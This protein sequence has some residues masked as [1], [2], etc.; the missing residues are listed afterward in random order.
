MSCSTSPSQMRAVFVTDYGGTD[1]LHLASIDVPEIGALDLLVQVKAAGVNV[2]DTMFREG[3][4]G[5]NVFPLVMGSDF[6]G[7]VVKV[8]AE[9]TEFKIGDEVFGYKLMGNGTYAEFASVPA[10][11]TAHKRMALS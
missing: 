3:Y 8:G 2:V 10:A 5:T 4:I 9:V 1:K 7:I 6:S 11:Y